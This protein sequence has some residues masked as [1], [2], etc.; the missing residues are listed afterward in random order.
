MTS[1]WHIDLAELL[2]TQWNQQ[3]TSLPSGRS[4]RSQIENDAWDT[5]CCIQE[6]V[7]WCGVR[8]KGIEVLWAALRTFLELSRFID[9]GDPLPGRQEVNDRLIEESIEKVLGN[10]G[11]KA[12]MKTLIGIP[13]RD[14]LL[15]RI[16]TAVA[17][18]EPIQKCHSPAGQCFAVPAR[19]RKLL[20]QMRGTLICQP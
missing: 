20:D 4:Q 13:Q 3:A 2:L 1:E 8:C 15:K 7:K 19:C 12:S 17:F 16:S 6:I 11:W 5:L 14:K 18:V 9:E 10:Y